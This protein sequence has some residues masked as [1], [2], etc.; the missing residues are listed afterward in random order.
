MGEK[1]G[2]GEKG[3]RNSPCELG[4]NLLNKSLYEYERKELN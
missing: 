2:K 4:I 3:E 1:W